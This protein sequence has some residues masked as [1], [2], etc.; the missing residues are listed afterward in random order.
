MN[1]GPAVLRSI[2]LSGF[3]LLL[4][5]SCYGVTEKLVMPNVTLPSH[6]SKVYE[7]VCATVLLLVLLSPRSPLGVAVRWW[8]LRAIGTVGYSFYLLH[9]FVIDFVLELSRKFLGF[10]IYGFPLFLISLVL[11]W[12]VCLFT[13]SHVE[14]PFLTKANEQKK[15]IPPVRKRLNPE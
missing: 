13:Y 9:P 7:L 1:T 15:H 5:A 3:A 11:T 8:P 12:V 14:R 6:F 4:V 2:V 10:S